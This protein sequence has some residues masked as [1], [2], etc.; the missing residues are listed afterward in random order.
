MA[1]NLY[2]EDNE[3]GALLMVDM[4]HISGLVAAGAHPSP[5]PHAHVVTSTTH[6]TLR[7]PRAGF[8]MCHP[9]FAKQIDS[10]VFPGFQG[11]PLEHVIA[12]KAVMF[13]E[14]LQP[15]FKDYAHKVVENSIEMAKLFTERGYRVVSGGTD[16][17]L[18]VLDLTNKNISGRDA[19]VALDLAAINANRNT[20]PFE[21]KSPFVTS[22]IRLGTA[23]LTTRGMGKAEIKF[24]VE[25]I[26]QSIMKAQDTNAL[27]EI[28]KQVYALC[29]KFPIYSWEAFK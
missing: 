19:E 24:I 16:N 14:A 22:G 28:R 8:I 17:H 20:I 4:A 25:L 15:N 5:F 18:L 27:Q 11:G 3:V 26:D 21:T 13:N 7:G 10:A 29:E 9:D 1:L 23:A 2:N 12:G 6:K